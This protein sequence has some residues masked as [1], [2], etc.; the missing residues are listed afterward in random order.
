[1][2]TCSVFRDRL[3]A[4]VSGELPPAEAAA[5]ERHAAA[6]GE[7]AGELERA[8]RLLG[9][10][11]ELPRWVDPPTDL[12]PEIDA[13]LGSET[14]LVRGSFG[15]PLRTWLAAAAV[16]VAAA[17]AVLVAYTVGRNHARVV[18]VGEQH[19][20]QAVPASIGDT[21]VEAV[22]AQFR[23]ARSELLVALEHRRDRLSP[24]T[25]DTV[26]RNL[27]V[28]DEA[29]VRISTALGADP[30]NPMLTGQLT[31]AYQHQIELLQLANR[32]PAEI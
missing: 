23:E 10:V 31:R 11:E 9:L 30:G 16:V 27:E 25:I 6:C 15:R 2:M 12:W 26:Y 32:L 7:C 13:R 3:D 1:M 29:I 17:G 14:R 21:S 24:E 8:R 28:I 4:L 5:A 20:S 22:E 19:V 18:A